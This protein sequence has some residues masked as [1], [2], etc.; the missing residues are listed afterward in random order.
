MH[1]YFLSS[2]HLLG[3]EAQSDDQY[4]KHVQMQYCLE[5]LVY[6]NEIYRQLLQSFQD[7]MSLLYQYI[8]PYLLLHLDQ[9]KVGMSHITYD[10]FEFYQS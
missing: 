6:L 9:L 4:Y 10:K 2:M 7:G 1:I 3:L 5:H 8:R